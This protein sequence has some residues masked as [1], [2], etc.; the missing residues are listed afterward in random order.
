[1]LFMTLNDHELIAKV[2]DDPLSFR[3]YI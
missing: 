1:V 3:T 2:T